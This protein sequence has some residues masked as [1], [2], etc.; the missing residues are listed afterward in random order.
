[1]VTGIEKIVCED[2]ERRQQAGMIK[3]GISV[4]DNPLLLKAWLQHSYEES[5]DLAVYLR[6]CISEVEKW[7]TNLKI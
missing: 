4:A 2:I 3:Y 5:L 1:M 6:R 7:D